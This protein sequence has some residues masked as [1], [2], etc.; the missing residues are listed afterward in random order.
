MRKNAGRAW[1]LIGSM[2]AATAGAWPL[3]PARAQTDTVKLG[4]LSAISNA[5]IYIAIEKGFFKEQGI[6]TE[7]SSFAS[8][9]KMVPALVAGELEVSVGSAS[10][11]LFNAVAQQAPFRIVA[12]K[13]QAR[14]GH[15][16]TLLTVRK[17]LVDSGQ[18]KSFRDLKGK[19]IALLAKGNI[20]HY[21]IGKMAE[22][23]GLT[24]NDVELTFLNAPSQL[25]ALETRAVDA[26]YAVEPWAARFQ[27]RGVAVRFRTPDEVRGLGPVQVGVIIYSG[28]FIAERRAVAQRWMNAYLKGAA[29]FHKNG[30][31]DPE[32][33]A[34]LE[35][36]TKV[37]ANTI[38][39]A[40][41]HYQEPNGR[42][43]V[44][45]LADQAEWFARNGMQQRVKV[46]NA[47]DL[48]FLKK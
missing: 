42:V 39:A 17:D 3:S 14:E 21:L 44:E 11:G 4:D 7:I 31:K 1:F 25:K 10:A 5:A 38:R 13:G 22:E 16:F 27:E 12:D 23:V 30:L 43:L 9:A 8:A 34:I 19:K 29:L 45:N 28:R 32:I 35:K 24:I 41:P 46:E 48:S 15:G 36:Y 47:L 6:V 26:A 37:P 20:Q 18:V 33:A 40:I 2:L